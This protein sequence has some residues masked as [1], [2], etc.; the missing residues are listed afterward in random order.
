MPALCGAGAKEVVES[1]SRARV[2]QRDMFNAKQVLPRSH[3]AWGTTGSCS[4]GC[5]TTFQ[6][7]MLEMWL[8]MAG[9]R[10]KEEK[11]PRK[12]MRSLPYVLLTLQLLVSFL[13]PP[14]SAM[15]RTFLL[16]I[17]KNVPFPWRAIRN[18]HGAE[19]RNVRGL[20]REQRLRG[21]RRANVCGVGRFVPQSRRLRR[22]EATPLKGTAK[23]VPRSLLPLPQ[24]SHTAF[25]R[26]F[27]YPCY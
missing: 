25:M 1:P 5:R 24:R 15:L 9:E 10:R 7:H 6:I 20:P 12:H 8:V 18:L 14:R 16:P 21:G 11:S 3:A 13:D 2:K 4:R 22:R 26:P 23:W 19:R 27:L 17:S